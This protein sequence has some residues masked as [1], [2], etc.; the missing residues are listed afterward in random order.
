MNEE[1]FIQSYFIKEIIT[2]FSKKG[3]CLMY[4]YSLEGFYWT[5]SGEEEVE[6]HASSGASW[7]CST[8]AHRGL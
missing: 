7:S 5:N 8:E 4:N 6:H 2:D 3:K 1:L